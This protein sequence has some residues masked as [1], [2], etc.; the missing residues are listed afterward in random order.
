M[1][2]AFAALVASPASQPVPTISLVKNGDAVRADPRYVAN[3]TP[4][5]L[6]L[7]F[8]RA[9]STAEY[10]R[11][12]GPAKPRS[13][14]WNSA[15]DSSRSVSWADSPTTSGATSVSINARTLAAPGPARV[16]KPSA[17][18]ASVV[19]VTT[20]TSTAVAPD[21]GE[22]VTPARGMRCRLGRGTR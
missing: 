13:R 22:V 4:A 17:A 1:S 20:T 7:A 16:V 11:L 18:P 3:G 5:A 8:Q 21:W 12:A 14:K 6:D 10:A 15:F 19:T 9:T 2:A